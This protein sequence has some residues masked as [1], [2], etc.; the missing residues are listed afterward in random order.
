M[1]MTQLL[2]YDLP[3]EIIRLWMDREGDALLP[4]QEKVVKRHGLFGEENLLVQA[5]TSSGKTFIGEMAGVRTALRRKKVVYLVPL[6][7]LAEEK[8]HDFQQKYCEYGLNVIVC[9]RDR[10]EFDQAFESG[11]FEIAIAV[12]EKLAQLL[13]RHPERAAE[14][15]LVIADELEILADPERGA[16]AELL[17]T[18]LLYGPEAEAAERRGKRCRLLGFSAVIGGADRLAEWMRAKL[19]YDERR[20]VELRYGV[21]YEG[22]F[23]Y[24]TYNAAGEGCE[25]LAEV[26][27]NSPW[28]VLT[29]NVCAFAGRGESCLIFVKAKHESR[30]G[31]ELLAMRVDLPAATEALDALRPLEPTRSRDALLETLAH[32]VAFHNADLRPE[33]RAIAERA[34][35]TGEAKVMVSTSTLAVGLNLPAQNVFLTADKWRYDRRLDM[36]WKTPIL[37]TEY[38]NM[39]GRAGR[40]GA[41]HEFGRS[42]LIA[43][44]PF[45]QETF[46]RRYV[47]GERE[48][49][50]PR[51]ATSA[52]EDHVLRLAASR[53]CRTAAELLAFLEHS[54]T[55]TWIWKERYT[56]E[57]I[58][59]HIRAAINRCTDAGV[60][61]AEPQGALEATPFGRAAAAKGISIATAR[62]L[63]HWLAQSETRDWRP[64]DLIFAAVST[65]DGRMLQVMLT[66]REYEHADYPAQIKERTRSEEL[67]ADVPL[68]RIRNCNLK[69]FF[70]EVR[71]IKVA[72]LLD[73]WIQHAAVRDLEDRYHT[74]A[75]Q[76][77]SAAEQVSWLVDA[78]HAL[79][80]A[81]GAR[82]PFL[83]RL[84]TLAERVRRGLPEELLPLARLDI[85]GLGRSALAAL[86]REGLHTLDALAE[87]PPAA[88]SRWLPK[89]T[90]KALRPVLGGRAPREKQPEAEANQDNPLFPALVIDDETPQQV[91]LDGHTIPLQEKQYRLIRILAQHPGACVPYETIYA[92]VWGE[93]VV[94]DNQMHFQKRKLLKRVREAVPGRETLVTTIRQRGFKLNLEPEEVQLNEAAAFSAA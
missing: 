44:T 57:E 40:Y 87:V 21:L 45:D 56:L 67:H 26:V 10:R 35:R 53:T 73:E 60:I 78:T 25:P 50:Q 61:R 7:A 18:R 94:E 49:I 15:D 79:A 1:K 36:P 55:A 5:P 23:R 43:V 9:T 32:G 52:L 70:E 17:L 3:P 71:A 31:A 66:A 14:I 75:G 88:L 28:E 20:P 54:L 93:A 13:V 38:E 39:S 37:R 30:R 47:E 76:I 19:V 83:G 85:G 41:G 33:E 58:E 63:A 72:L 48:A 34:F 91:L 89:D 6:K 81:S 74:M 84:Q 11:D 16:M 12:Y 2:A 8:Y 27:S 90:V 68:N 29:H 86:H 80:A 46:W 62:D 42:I 24:R 64:I 65:C 69:P 22:E 92:S 51:L 77:F 4:L 82:A 59:F